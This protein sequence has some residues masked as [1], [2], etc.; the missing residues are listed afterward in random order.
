MNIHHVQKLLWKQT[1]DEEF[2]IALINIFGI[3]FPNEN[4]EET[5]AESVLIR[6]WYNKVTC[7]YT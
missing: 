5:S 6:A 1:W 4:T 2:L 3:K 7:V